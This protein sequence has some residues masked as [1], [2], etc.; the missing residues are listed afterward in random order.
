MQ[1]IPV[2]KNLNINEG[3]IYRPIKC[4]NLLKISLK[5]T[6]LKHYAFRCSILDLFYTSQS[7]YVPKILRLSVFNNSHMSSVLSTCSRWSL[8]SSVTLFSLSSFGS[9]CSRDSV[10]SFTSR[11]TWFTRLTSWSGGSKFAMISNFTFYS[12]C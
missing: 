3:N 8:R 12:L 11:W 7:A 5:I 6:T 2:D 9:R 4:L 10:T 1:F